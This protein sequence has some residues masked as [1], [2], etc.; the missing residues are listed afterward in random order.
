MSNVLPECLRCDF[1]EPQDDLV[2]E[3][4]RRA[5]RPVA[6]SGLD[7]NDPDAMMALWPVVSQDDWCGE[8]VEASRNRSVRNQSLMKNRLA[9]AQAR[10]ARRPVETKD[11]SDVEAG[12]A[13]VGGDA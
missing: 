12:D 13:D 1:F 7:F 5:P 11:A 6:A 9:D 8:F 3:C 4:R 2:G 10:L